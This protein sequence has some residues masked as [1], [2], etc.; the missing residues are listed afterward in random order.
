MTDKKLFDVLKPKTNDFVP[1]ESRS[2]YRARSNL[3]SRLGRQNKLNVSDEE[4][5]P[6]GLHYDINRG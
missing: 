5:Q 6:K 2:A 4:I 1:N 3:S